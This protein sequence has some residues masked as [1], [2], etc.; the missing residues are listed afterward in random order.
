MT[1]LAA[2]RDTHLTPAEIAAE[3]LR[4]FDE[5]PREPSIRSLAA[6]LHVAPTAI[7][8]H[9]PS[10][11]A[12]YQA[13]VELVWGEVVP[14]MLELVPKPLSADPA[15]VLVA[16][17][18]ATRRAWLRH[19][20]LAPYMTATPEANEFTT[21]TL[22][23]MASLFERLG[24]EGEEAAACFHSYAS[25]MVGAVLFAATRRTANEQL[26]A[27]EENDDSK[28]RFHV[29]HSA[30]ASR[31]SGERTRISIDA[32]MDLSVVAPDHD[33]NLFEEGLRR[34]VQSFT[35]QPGAR[36]A[37][38]GGRRNPGPERRS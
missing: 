4:Q 29:A 27:K 21:K 7:Y 2:A 25:F 19:Y 36:R 9:F 20:R 28:G 38:R 8:H 24:L 31:Q 12:I 5:H 33:E 37:A 16:G 17:G 23:L 3:A 18:V 30:G 32:V 6:A 11:A 14:G 13:A 34:L 26:R 35:A 1:R 22:G 10:Q 15:E